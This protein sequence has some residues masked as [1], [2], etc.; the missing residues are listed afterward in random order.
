MRLFDVSA[1]VLPAA[2]K[3]VQLKEFF[4]PSAR[5]P[6]DQTDLMK[7]LV[8]TEMPVPRPKAG[9]VLIK[10]EAAPIQP[11]DFWY[12]QG[13]YGKVDRPPMVP[14]IEGAGT[15]V[16]AG[17][18]VMPRMLLGQKVSCGSAQGYTG[19]WA[20][21]MVTKADMCIPLLPWLDIEQGAMLMANPLSAWKL[22]DMART[23]KARAL[24]NNGAA[25]A[26]GRCLLHL[27]RKAGMTLIN[28]VDRPEQARLLRE[29]GAEWVIDRSQS[30]YQDAMNSLFQRHRVTL[31]LDT[32]AGSASNEMLA[33]MPE[34]GELLI[35]GGLSE[36]APP[37][38]L[39]SIIFR[40]KKVSGF[41]VTPWAMA[42]NK[43]RMAKIAL[44]L[45]NDL[46]RG[47]AITVKERI[48]LEQVP[49]SIDGYL[50]CM[51]EGKY[52]INPFR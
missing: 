1:N 21:Y 10:I 30:D 36:E 48:S 25:S 34:G 8:V 42:Q 13:R 49:A 32:L 5:F 27:A 26:L 52:M 22:L 3:V 23:R 9:E 31:A 18:G 39:S 4:D 29:L 45:Q 2:M 38:D 51:T 15:V 40:N 46:H 33:A 37:I 11:A 44:C 16:A 41:W 19:T 50:K 43:L 20:Q 7:N 17:S 28:I 35:Y 24:A 47:M 12:M 6:R 14:G